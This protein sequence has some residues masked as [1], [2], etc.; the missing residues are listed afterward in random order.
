V[1]GNAILYRVSFLPYIFPALVVMVALVTFDPIV[2][3]MLQMCKPHRLIE[4]SLVIF[5]ED[6]DLFGCVLSCQEANGEK[7]KAG[8]GNH[9]KGHQ[10]SVHG[11]YHLLLRDGSFFTYPIRKSRFNDRVDVKNRVL[12]L[13]R[14]ARFTS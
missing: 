3:R 4:L 6:H 1:A 12:F 9:N 8:E 2:L 10:S 7:H 5:V 13:V 11:S 14:R